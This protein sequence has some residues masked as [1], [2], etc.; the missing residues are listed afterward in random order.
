MHT[1]RTENGALSLGTTGD[2]RLNLFFKTT[3]DVAKYNG[4]NGFLYEL[5]DRSWDV[6]PLDTMKVLMNWRDCRGG[7]GDHCGFVIAMAYICEHHLEWFAA[8]VNIIPEFGSYLDLIKLWHYSNRYG[9]H[10]IMKFIV[11]TLSQDVNAQ[12]PSLLAKW[13]PSEGS[14]WDRYTIDTPF[15][16]VLCAEIFNLPM[17]T[18][19]RAHHCKAMRQTILSPLRQKLKLV[20]TSL[21]MK[22]YD[23]IEYDHIPSVAMNKYKKAFVRNDGVR[24]AEYMEAV[25]NGERKINASQVFPHTLVQQCMADHAHANEVVEAQWRVMKEHYRGKGIFKNSMCVCDV[26]ASMT[27]TP[28]CVAIALGLLAMDDNNQLITFSESPQLFRVPNGSLHRQVRTI[29]DLMPWGGNT[30]FERVMDIVLGRTSAAQVDRVFIFS[31]M[32]FDEAVENDRSHFE[33][34][35]AMFKIAGVVHPQIIFWNLRGDTH[36]FPVYRDDMSVVLL[37]GYSPSIMNALLDNDIRDPLSM[38]F[39]IIRSARYDIVTTP[40]IASSEIKS[41]R[42]VE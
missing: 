11:D 14:R 42:K 18:P 32:Q 33:R 41:L 38:M 6:D 40:S 27:G 39:N 10:L 30:N 35:K 28:M 23:E 1:T 5:I 37:S 19:V 21:C 24:F 3:R 16:H 17:S 36:D 22:R 9:K 25:K 2:A 31:D 34:I 20:E 7:K 29:I 15:Y 13:I 8:N 4:D 12:Q 26:S